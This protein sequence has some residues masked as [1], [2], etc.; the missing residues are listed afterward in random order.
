MQNIPVSRILASIC[1][2]LIASGAYLYL[3]L[4]DLQISTS[5]E[6]SS[7]SSQLTS[8]QNNISTLQT[9]YSSAKS[10]LSKTEKELANAYQSLE[11]EK[12][13][14]QTA[15]DELKSTKE[16]LSQTQLQ[17][18]AAQQKADGIKEEVQSLEKNLNASMSWFKQNSQLNSQDSWDI[19]IFLKRIRSDCI[20]NNTLNLPCINYLNERTVLHL[21]Y[22]DDLEAGETD[23]LQSL[24]QS[25]KRRGGD[26]EDYAL[27]FKAIMQTLKSDDDLY[28]KA[29]EPAQ[30]GDYVVWPQ[31]ENPEMYVY[32]NNARGRIISNLKNSHPY[33]MCYTADIYSGHCR[34]AL[35]ENKLTSDTI[36]NLDGAQVFEPQTGK[37]GGTVGVNYFVCAS[38]QE[39]CYQTPGAITL[40]ISDS[41]IIQITDSKWVSYDDYLSQTEQ[42]SAILN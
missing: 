30:S 10:M 28:L 19:D 6:I 35:S 3:A 8:A 21:E 23:H 37:F 11:Q 16:N 13:L 29:W 38:T 14:K 1:V 12:I 18:N 25:I 39:Q 41:D 17:L 40:V 34:I 24:E 36:Q 7:L 22:L 15:L 20:L 4:S 31:V 26:C 27:F 9:Q 42:I 32:Y 5:N 2:F 33:V